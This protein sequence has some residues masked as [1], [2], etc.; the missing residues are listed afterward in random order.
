MSEMFLILDLTEPVSAFVLS[1][2]ELS[3]GVCAG[4]SSGGM[5][6]VCKAATGQ[7]GS[8]SLH[9]QCHGKRWTFCLPGNGG[10]DSNRHQ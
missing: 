9:Y 6:D 1:R 3:W 4:P 5:E 10:G 7:G 2:W 8:Q